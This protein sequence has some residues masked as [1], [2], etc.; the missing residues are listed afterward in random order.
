MKNSKNMENEQKLR[1]KATHY[2]KSKEKVEDQSL[3]VD[4]RNPKY[5]NMHHLFVIFF[6]L[7][8]PLFGNCQN[9][10]IQRSLQQ[11]D[12]VLY[13]FSDGHTIDAVLI[14]R[15]NTKIK[16]LYFPNGRPRE[17][18][19]SVNDTLVSQI[20]WYRNGVKSYEY[21]YKNGKVSGIV[22]RYYESGKLKCTQNYKEGLLDGKEVWYK[23]NGKVD[24]ISYYSMGDKVK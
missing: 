24:E 1:G 17:M 23:E 19:V 10:D 13:T 22:R 8:F 14:L 3:T 18:F 5:M 4:K 20:G 7:V 16:N 6:F 11:K 21:E 15:E 12:T 9:N 2:K